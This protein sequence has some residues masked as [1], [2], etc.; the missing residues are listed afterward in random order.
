M[1]KELEDIKDSVLKD[2]PDM[3]KSQA[4]AIATNVFK[5]RHGIKGKTTEEEMQEKA[6][7]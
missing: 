2:N 4:Y 7:E 3:G 5:K 1:P 6:S